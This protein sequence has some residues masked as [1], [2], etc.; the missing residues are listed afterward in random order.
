MDTSNDELRRQLAESRREQAEVMPVWREALLRAFADGRVEGELVTEADKEAMVLG[1]L[2][3]RRFL[4]FGGLSVASAAVLAACGG[5]SSTTTSTNVPQVGLPGSTAAAPVRVIDDITLLR[6]AS[7]LEYSAIAAYTAAIPLLPAGIASAAKLFSDQHDEHAKQFK[8][9][10]RELG[11]EP[12]PTSNVAVDTNVIAPAFEAIKTLS[13]QA[14]IDAIVNFARALED[15]ASATYGSFMTLLS[16]PKL[17]AVTMS[18]GA[19][20]A[21]HSAILTSL[22]PKFRIVPAVN[23]A[24][25]PTTTTAAGATTTTSTTTTVAEGA[26]T[27]TVPEIPIHYQVPGVFESQVGALG[28]NSYEYSNSP[29][30]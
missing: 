17:R 20:E 13:G 2:P 28:Q 26:T 16:Q 10:T 11:G 8:A 27:T 15:V 21:H 24:V 14:Q 23:P 5:S 29:S 3:R 7:S 6:T 22:L 18:V 30:K 1:A 19:I 12:F 25:V 4:V 9:T